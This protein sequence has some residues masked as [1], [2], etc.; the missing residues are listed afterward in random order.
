MI[1]ASPYRFT[2]RVNDNKMEG[3]AV[4]PG[5]QQPIAWRAAKVAAPSK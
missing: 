4:T 5:S 2:G 1:G 3:T